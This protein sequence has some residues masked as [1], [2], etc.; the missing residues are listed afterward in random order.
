M[1]IALIEIAGSRVALA[2]AGGL[3]LLLALASRSRLLSILV[4]AVAAA[5]Q[6]PGIVSHTQFQWGWLFADGLPFAQSP[7]I[8]VVGLALAAAPAGTY[9]L[10]T[11][12]ALVLSQP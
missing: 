2:M 4:V 10:A 1:D 8:V 12:A 3:L 9:G 6:L 5:A 7:N 11:A